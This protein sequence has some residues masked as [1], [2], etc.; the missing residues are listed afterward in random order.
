[1]MNM[2]WRIACTLSL[3]SDSRWWGYVSGQNLPQRPPAVCDGDGAP[4]VVVDGHFRVD[5]QAV[6]N[7]RANV[8]DVG[9]PVLDEGR[10]RVGGA[11]DAAAADAG[12][13]QDHG[14]AVRPV[15]AATGGVDL[16]RAAHLAH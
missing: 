10:L 13:G 6:I 5:A 3:M 1:M 15:V 11:V 7:R 8:A 16:R 2:P 4:A 14:V 12:P 9:R